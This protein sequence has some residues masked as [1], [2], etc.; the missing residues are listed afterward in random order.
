MTFSRGV[1][2]KR[3]ANKV[4]FI[5]HPKLEDPIAVIAAGLT[6]YF[7]KFHDRACRQADLISDNKCEEVPEPA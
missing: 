6:T 2:V 1:P 5:Q 3:Y 4:H 7:D